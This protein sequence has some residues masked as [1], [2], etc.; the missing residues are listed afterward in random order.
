M[1]ETEEGDLGDIID[2][3]ADE[4]GRSW[5]AAP[6]PPSTEAARAGAARANSKVRAWL[7][8]HCMHAWHQAYS[9][10]KGPAASR[11]RRE[12]E[13]RTSFAINQSR[14]LRLLCLDQFA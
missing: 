3:A 5:W 6:S 7:S 10:A 2:D 8:V 14:Q 4:A 11:T 9:N 1:K 13:S 12:Q